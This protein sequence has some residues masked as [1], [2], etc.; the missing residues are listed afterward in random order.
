MLRPPAQA[1][2]W[3]RSLWAWSRIE[4]PTLLALPNERLGFSR[5]RNEKRVPPYTEI[6]AYRYVVSYLAESAV[7]QAP[8]SA[9]PPPLEKAVSLTWTSRLPPVPAAPPLG[10][11]PVRIVWHFPDGRVIDDAPALPE[12]GPGAA[13][14]K[15]EPVA[16]TRVE[17][18]RSE[19]RLRVSIRESCGN[20]E[21]DR[22]AYDALVRA[23]GEYQRRLSAGGAV[24]AASWFP[25][26]G[27]SV[28]LEVEWRL[29]PP[30]ATAATDAATQPETP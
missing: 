8:L 14:A 10:R 28:V 19:N 1:R 7:Q 13:M 24:S 27:Q 20:V 9:P 16:P 15:K 21:L 2:R 12:G 25:G 29:A 3:E 26:P 23:A 11:A 6:P 30:A 5:V 4:D 18:I 17:V 22:M